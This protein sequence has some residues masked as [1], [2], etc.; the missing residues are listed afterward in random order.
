MGCVQSWS[1]SGHVASWTFTHLYGGTGHSGRSRRER[2]GHWLFRRRGRGSLS[3]GMMGNGECCAK[4]RNLESGQRAEPLQDAHKQ[5]SMHVQCLTN[6]FNMQT[7]KLCQSSHQSRVNSS[8][9]PDA[10]CPFPPPDTKETYWSVLF[11]KIIA[12][13]SLNSNVEIYLSLI[14]IHRSQMYWV[15]SCHIQ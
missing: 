1:K 5:R 13:Q 7:S 14:I 6:P 12:L 4:A 11:C 8:Y 10:L 3:Q 15:L 9:Q 2:S